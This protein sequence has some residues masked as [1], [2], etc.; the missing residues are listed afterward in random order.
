MRRLFNFLCVAF[1]SI[2]LFSNCNTEESYETFSKIEKTYSNG[3]KHVVL[4]YQMREDTV[5]QVKKEYFYD[6]GEKLMEGPVTP[7][8]KRNGHWKAYFQNGKIKSEGSFENDKASG[9]R[10]VY[11]DNGQKRYEGKYKNGKR[12]GSWHFW[13]K[14]G[15]LLKTESY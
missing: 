11:Y 7:D 5:Y 13:D 10:T 12:S 2:A 8:G 1:I 14:N 6:S 15:K 4:H 3:K 9:K